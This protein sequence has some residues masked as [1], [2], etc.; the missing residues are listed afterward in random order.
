MESCVPKTCPVCGNNEAI[1]IHE[2]LGEDGKFC[3]C[4][5]DTGC[6]TTFILTPQ[7]RVTEI[8]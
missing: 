1:R 8:F 4:S 6:G 5:P 2:D 7:G 3:I